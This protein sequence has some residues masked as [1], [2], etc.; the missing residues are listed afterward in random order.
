MASFALSL[1]SA[2]ANLRRKNTTITHSPLYLNALHQAKLTTAVSMSSP[3]KPAQ[4]S[5]DET[6]ESQSL[7]VVLPVEQ[8]PKL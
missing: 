2:S 5:P 6:F 8:L 7:A 1:S 3:P 4:K